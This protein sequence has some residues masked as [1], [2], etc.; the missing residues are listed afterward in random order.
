M[1]GLVPSGEWEDPLFVGAATVT[2]ISFVWTIFSTASLMTLLARRGFG[3][4]SHLSF[5]RTAELIII[6]TL[7]GIAASMLR[8]PLL[9]IPGIF[10]WIRLTP[11]P[12]IVLFD[13]G[14]QDGKK[15]ALRAARIF[16]AGHKAR[17]LLLL[18]P[19]AVIFIVE[20]AGETSAKDAIPI[21]DAPLQHTGS[22]MVFSALR[23][24]VD[25]FVLSKYKSAL[26]NRE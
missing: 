8:L 12:Y 4:T 5:F 7:R 2:L 1:T 13:R 18:I 17:V 15:D 6:E 25:A 20:L 19:V 11:I 22:I 3:S 24:A 14:Y 10:E 16:F 23:L 9:I 21:W 26:S